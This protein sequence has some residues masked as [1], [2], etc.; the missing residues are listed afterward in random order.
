M[1]FGYCNLCK[2]HLSGGDYIIKNGKKIC[3]DC[4]SKT[5][6]DIAEKEKLLSYIKLL[7]QKKDVP[8][9]WLMYI[10]KQRKQGK[11]YSGMQGTLYYFYDLMGN[12]VSYESMTSLG[13]IDYVYDE[14]RRY[15]EEINKV[16]EY[17]NK[18][19]LQEETRHYNTKLPESKKINID[20]GDL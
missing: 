10:E 18:V 7:F 11:T 8:E 15:F 9:S 16:N 4:S 2:K 1:E 19:V 5:K 3:N 13:I 20:I 17:N 14:A 6:D 12:A